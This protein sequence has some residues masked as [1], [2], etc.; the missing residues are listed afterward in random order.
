MLLRIAS[1]VGVAALVACG[2]GGKKEDTVVSDEGDDDTSEEGGGGGDMVPLETLDE[3]NQTLD[4][5]GAQ[6]S[7]CLT[8]AIDSGD[9]TKET[10]G[11]ITVEFVVTPGGRAKDVSVAQASID[12]PRI[13][14][15]IVAIVEKASFPDVPNDVGSSYTFVLEA[16]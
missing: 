15:C 11:K 9:A 7:R 2:G 16:Y 14:E 3:I 8:D 5:K 12:V 4:R 6:A 13:Q 10:H 1:L